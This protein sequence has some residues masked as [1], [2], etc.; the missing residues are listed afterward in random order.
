MATT[1][2]TLITGASSGIGKAL[3]AIAAA[4]GHNLVLVA[5][6]TDQLTAIARDLTE[7]YPIH[8]EIISCDLA[9]QGGVDTIIDTLTRKQLPV[10]ILINNAGVGDYGLFAQSNRS[11]Q[12]SMIDL[13]IRSLTELT[14]RLLPAMTSRG[15]GRIMN[16]ASVAGFMPGP[17]MSVYFATKA[18]VLSFSEALAEELRESGVTVTCLCPGSTKTSFGA[19]AHVSKTHSTRTSNVSADSVAQFGWKAME[20][21]TPVAIHGFANRYSVWALRWMPRQFVR[22]AVKQL[23]R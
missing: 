15:Q 10:N 4:H 5:R 13:N 2:Y 3:A 9:T 23:Q 1:T 21:G 17:L 19:T 14:H 11:T 12:L 8:C 16:V 6:N 18:Y 22:R 20:R 7:R